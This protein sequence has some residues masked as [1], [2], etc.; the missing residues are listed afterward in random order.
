MVITR[1][2]GTIRISEQR[3]M[4]VGKSSDLILDLLFCWIRQHGRLK[5]HFRICDKGPKS[6]VL[7]HII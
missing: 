1:D 5:R 7:A 4:D 2:Y 6:R 3:S